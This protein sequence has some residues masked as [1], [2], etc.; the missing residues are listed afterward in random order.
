MKRNNFTSYLLFGMLFV[1]FSCSQ[2]QGFI[3]PEKAGLSSDTLRLAEAKMQQYL[4][5]GKFAGVSLFVMKDDKTV[6]RTNLGYAEKQSGKLLTDSSIFRIYSMT[7]PVTTVALMTLFD[8]GK[9]QLDD[10][11]SQY[12]P[13]FKETMVYNPEVKKDSLEFQKNEMTIRHLLTHTSGLTYG[14]DPNSYVDWLYV[15]YRPSG[16]DAPLGEK[17][18]VLSKLPLKYQPGTHYEYGL[19]VDVAGYLVEVL[20]GMPLDQYMKNKVFDPL[21]MDDTGF[22]VPENK[23]NRLAGLYFADKEGKLILAGDTLGAQFN[24]NPILFS[25]GGGLVST[26]DDYT[27]FCRM[28][29]HKGE[30]DGARILKESTV[31]LIMSNQLPPGVIYKEGRGYGL[32]GEVNLNTGVY[33]WSGAASTFFWVNPK[34]KMIVMTFMQLMPF[35]TAYAIPFKQIVDRALINPD[36]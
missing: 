25:G 6:W 13:D 19:S 16:W 15:K 32:G 30:L 17:M 1:L 2:K 36:K 21:K 10:K 4:D 3:K 34:T 5:S 20:S 35:T 23:Q 11:V 7:K 12:I 29:L 26:I 24:K 33:A 14:W 18:K 22:W 31:D 8:E 27:R 9:F 28:L